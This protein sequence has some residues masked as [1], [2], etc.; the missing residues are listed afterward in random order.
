MTQLHPVSLSGQHVGFCHPLPRPDLHGKETSTR[1]EQNQAPGWKTSLS[2]ILGKKS[3]RWKWSRIQPRRYILTRRA[4]EIQANCCLER[5]V[6]AKFWYLHS[7][8]NNIVLSFQEKQFN[9]SNIWLHVDFL[10]FPKFTPWT[11]NLGLPLGSVKG[12]YFQ[13]PVDFLQFLQWTMEGNFEGE[14]KN[15]L[16]HMA[17]G[18]RNLRTWTQG[19]WKRMTVYLKTSPR[20]WHIM[21]ILLVDLILRNPLD[22][23]YL[24][25]NE[26]L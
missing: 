10:L 24:L 16:M 18:S 26:M 22:L 17:L 14:S 2:H 23:D 21:K 20:P 9:Q 25:D 13:L 6:Q 12:G 3:W 5:I 8:K 7:G 15:Y 11:Q 4:L 19:Q 1:R